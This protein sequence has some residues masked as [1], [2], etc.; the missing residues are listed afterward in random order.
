M[1]L[2]A[3][4]DPVPDEKTN[5]DPSP[6]A[7]ATT[8]PI[9]QP[10]AHET[11]AVHVLVDRS[12]SYSHLTDASLELL[13]E[14]VPEAA[15]PGDRFVFGWISDNPNLPIETFFNEEVP[16]VTPPELGEFPAPTPVD[17]GPLTTVQCERARQLE[18]TELPLAICDLEKQKSEARTELE[19]WQREQTTL[20]DS[21][22]ESARSA[23]NGQNP[24]HPEGTL[25]T[26]ALYRAARA[27]EGFLDGGHQSARLVIFS[28]LEE[29]RPATSPQGPLLLQLDGVDVIVAMFNCSRTWDVLTGIATEPQ[30]CERHRTRWEP[31]FMSASAASVRF[32]TLEASTVS[33]LAGLVN[34]D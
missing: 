26:E 28:D 20:L 16:F 3:S 18:L 25:V 21:F 14:F 27:L 19:D 15:L 32:L 12:P 31:I 7:C 6:T 9:D 22:R 10:A 29:A 11:K 30:V 8:P 2:A 23:A 13:A 5:S 1:L 24:E 34:E 4:C 33:T 17:C